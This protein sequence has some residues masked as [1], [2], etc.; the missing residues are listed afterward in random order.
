MR[1]GR[2]I[3]LSHKSFFLLLLYKYML[4][5]ILENLIE[6]PDGQKVEDIPICNRE[7]IEVISPFD[8]ILNADF[9]G[10]TLNEIT[11]LLELAHYREGIDFSGVALKYVSL[12]LL[13]PIELTRDKIKIAQLLHKIEFW[14]FTY[15]LPR[16]YIDLAYSIINESLE[17]KVFIPILIDYLIDIRKVTICYDFDIKIFIIKY[18]KE[19]ELQ[20]N[21][22][23]IKFLGD[24]V[25]SDKCISYNFFEPFINCN[26]VDSLI[27]LACGNPK[28]LQIIK[29]I[30]LSI[31][32]NNKY[33]N[34]NDHLKSIR[35]S[36]NYAPYEEIKENIENVIHLLKKSTLLPEAKKSNIVKLASTIIKRIEGCEEE[37]KYLI[38]YSFINEN[39]E[40]DGEML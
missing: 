29:G 21:E 7:R 37:K 13:T 31:V 10:F 6:V 30:P 38:L 1:Q 14:K 11:E 24:F 39:E 25:I 9:S 36:F 15:D 22:M 5:F 32:F 8:F 40:D 35:T 33:D 12:F 23:F 28:Y 27:K 16:K 2:A 3:V 20:E 18:A 19:L 34:I 26:Y 17:T 4:P